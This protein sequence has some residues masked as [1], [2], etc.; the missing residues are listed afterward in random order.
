[1]SLVAPSVTRE[2]Y[3]FLGWS[4]TVPTTTPAAN[5]TY[6]A[7]W[8]LNQY[9][10]TFDA[11][12]GEGDTNMT[13]DYGV[14][15][16][17][18]T[19]TREGYTFLGWSPSVPSMVPATNTTYIAQ[20]QINQYTITFDAAGGEGGTSVTQ[21]YGS[22]LEIPVVTREGYL[23]MGWSPTPPTIVPSTNITCVAQWQK[24]CNVVVHIEGSGT[25]VGE[26]IYP[27]GAEISLTAMPNEKSVFCGWSTTPMNGNETL[28]L[29]VPGEDLT[30]TAYFMDASALDVYLQ[31][32]E[33]VSQ[34][35]ID[36]RVEKVITERGLLTRAELKA[37]A[38]DSPVV[39]VKNGVATL[40]VNLKQAA[41][42]EELSSN[43]VDSPQ[44]LNIKV[45]DDEKVLL[46]KVVKPSKE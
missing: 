14:A 43:A 38:K 13:L 34:E 42:L 15:L 9:T 4:P 25:V 7:Q 8:Q 44:Q 28:Q 26:G 33:S 31:T 39:E 22:S 40:K 18:P 41:S 27:E 17:A 29:T 20:W 1:L 36:A 45:A 2:G 19:V 3:T 37:L 35:V 32:H 23:F 6:T 11:N 30:L 16:V 5:V 12:G 10:Q 21:D 24:A 46:Y